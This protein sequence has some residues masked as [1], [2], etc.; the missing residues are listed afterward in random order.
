MRVV[1]RKVPRAHTTR[2][3]CRPTSL[4]EKILKKH[5]VLDRILRGLLP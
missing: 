3:V 5:R 2:I 4:R 1:D